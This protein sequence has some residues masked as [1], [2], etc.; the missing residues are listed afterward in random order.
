MRMSVSVATASQKILPQ[1]NCFQT[2]ASKKFKKVVG[3]LALFVK[4]GHQKISLL[5][6]L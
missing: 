6:W 1:F 3:I 2:S 4:V 5:F